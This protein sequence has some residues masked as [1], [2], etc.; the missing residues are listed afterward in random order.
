M[1]LHLN[2]QPQDLFAIVKQLPVSELKKLSTVI[3]TELKSKS[4]NSDLKKL[5]LN[6]PTW[7][8]D[9]YKKHL[10]NRASINKSRLG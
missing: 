4:K 5:L 7:T 2:I 3:D 1:L 10:E 9:E 8:E 6:S